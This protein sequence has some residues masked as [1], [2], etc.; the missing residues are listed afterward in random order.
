MRM[1]PDRTTPGSSSTDTPSIDESLHRIVSERLRV[2]VSDPTTDLFATGMVDSLGLVELMLALE[3][4]FGILV[5]PADLDISV[6]RTL[7]SASVF[8]EKHLP[9]SDG[10]VRESI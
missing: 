1:Y 4:E 2:D 5:D 6:F 3:E 7:E 9:G 10:Q 8:I